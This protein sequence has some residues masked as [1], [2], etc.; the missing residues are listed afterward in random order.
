M[1]KNYR[2]LPML[3]AL[4]VGIAT[5]GCVAPISP[6]YTAYREDVRQHAFDQGRTKGLARGVD[7]S[8]HGRARPTS[9]TRNIATPMV[10][11]AVATATVTR[12]ARSSRRA[13][14]PAT[15]K[16]SPSEIRTTGIA[17]ARRHQK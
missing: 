16:R 1:V 3:L 15:R 11:T 9:G 12:I 13:S 2:W 5:P 14:G 8:R 6:R 4:G 10:V 7:D 17:D